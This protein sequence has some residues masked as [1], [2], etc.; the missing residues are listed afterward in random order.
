M[1]QRLSIALSALMLAGLLV[2]P[3]SVAAQGQGRTTASVRDTGETDAG[4]GDVA[5]FRDRLAA[6]SGPV[7]VFVEL[8]AAPVAEA[9]ARAEASGMSPAAAA[10]E[11]QSQLARI[12]RAQR[13]TLSR[14]QAVDSTATTLF[15]SQRVVNGFGMRVDAG[16]LAD[17]LT[18]PGVRRVSR[19][20]S[21][22]RDNA[23]GVPFIGAPQAWSGVAGAAG[24]TG[25]GMKIGII[26]TGIDYHHVTFGGP[27]NA[28]EAN[29]PTIITDAPS[30][31]FFGPNAPKVKGGFDFAGDEYDGDNDPTPDPDPVDC[32]DPAGDGGHGTHV[33]GT[34]GGFGVTNAGARYTGP[35]NA[36]TDFS[37]LRV[38]PGVAPE[39]DLYAL[40]VFG[41]SGSTFLVIPAIEWSVDPNGDGNLSDRLD[42]IN[43]SLGSAFGRPDDPDAVA[44]NNASK[45]GVVVVFSAGNE[46]NTTYVSGAP[47]SADYAITVAASVDPVD[48]VD[49][50]RVDSP[51]SIQGVKPATFSAAYAWST[52][53]D[54]SGDMI[55]IPG[56]G[57]STGCNVNGRSPYTAGQLTDRVLLVDWAPQGT[58]NF[59]CGSAQRANNAAAAGAVGIIMASGVNTFDSSIAGNAAIPAVF[60]TY[61]VGAQLKGASGTVRI[62]FSNSFA[63]NTPFAP[64]ELIDTLAGFTSRGPR[65]GDSA[66]KPDIAAPGQGVFSAESLSGNGGLS[67]NGTSMAAPH[68]AGVMALL[69]Q[70]RPT[71]S[72]PELKALAMNTAVND[73]YGVTNGQPPLQS[74][75]RAGTGRVDVA[76]AAAGTVIAYNTQR[77]E[78]VSVSFGALEVL[79]TTTLTRTVTVKNFGAAAKTYT[80]GFTADTTIPGVSYA[81][82]PASITVP[83]GGTATVTVALTADPAQMRHVRDPLSEPVQGNPSLPRHYLSEAAGTIDL[84]APAP[85]PGSQ[86]TA[87]ATP[88]LRLGV[89]A[90]ARPASTMSVAPESLGFGKNATGTAEL[91]F[92]GV[93][94]ITGTALPTDVVSLATLFEL[95]DI[96]GLHSSG[97]AAEADLSHIGVAS[98]FGGSTSVVSST[99]FFGLASHKNWSTPTTTEFDVYIDTDNSGIEDDGTGA[100]YILFNWNTGSASNLDA[101]DVFLTFLYDTSSEDFVAVAPVNVV[102]ASTVD[103]QP[104]NTNVLVLPVP[105]GD[106]GLTAAASKINYRV[107]GISAYEGGVEFSR[108]LSY[109][110]AK[111]GVA[112]TSAAT[113]PGTPAVQDLPTTKVSVAFNKANFEANGS[114]GV[115]VLHHHNTTGTRVE[116]VQ[117]NPR[118][119]LPLIAKR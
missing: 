28:Y 48:I 17:I 46:G 74:V 58:S 55:Y 36:T 87:V 90:T 11:G 78:L 88:E 50:F 30:V 100:E 57:T 49:G 9:V 56:P 1:K 115:L 62:T 93:G 102:P 69:R 31:A 84:Y 10:T 79:T 41:C 94:R 64:P 24:A 35:Y 38:G 23:S 113:I 59:P 3:F 37:T 39:A 12:E 99:I 108:Q 25:R 98:T 75:V 111:P 109:D 80:T 16:A 112:F 7:A 4:G 103:T 89:Y 27:G 72:V 21:Y 116:V 91:T 44:A 61:G 107:L 117:V 67:L 40:R 85:A 83:A 66:L 119:F 81:V 45:S 29:N 53:P 20:P 76:R 33:A 47:G 6:R 82:S 42:V 97:F 65:G 32:L 13:S 43:L 34:A 60:T 51:A 19:L 73:L 95:Q 96:S 101:T 92:S 63:E 15:A 77:P 5:A 110:V 118:L 22:T 2:M 105:A 71:L 26:D 54:V 70:L 14:I 18:V 104:F 106:L 8:D 68:I 114:K 52:K 86:P